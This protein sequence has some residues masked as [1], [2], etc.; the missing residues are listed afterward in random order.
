[1]S[2]PSPLP[3]DDDLVE[4]QPEPE[5]ALS[6]EP[7][8]WRD[9]SGPTDERPN[10]HTWIGAAEIWVSDK[11]AKHA[12][13]RLSFRA[14]AGQR[15]DVLEVYCRACK[16]PYDDAADQPCAAT[17]DKTHLIGGN[18]GQ[19]KKRKLPVHDETM[20]RE[21][22]PVISRQGIEALMDTGWL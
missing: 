18:P 17:I 8:A 11:V 10:A 4:E 21:A 3:L 6:E 13:L 22:G 12:N 9:L 1:M 2:Q 20:I 16:R 7:D 15:V 14:Y 19:R 5:G